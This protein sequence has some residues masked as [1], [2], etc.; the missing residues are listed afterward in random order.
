[1]FTRRVRASLPWLIAVVSF[2]FAAPATAAEL[3]IKPSA[4]RGSVATF[5]LRGITGHRVVAASLHS[6]RRVRR[7]SAKAIRRASTRRFA[8]LRAQ[9][10]SRRS[11]RLVVR[12]RMA[13]VRKPR[14][15]G[16]TTTTT[17]PTPTTTTTTTEPAPA[18]AP[19]PAPTATDTA[20]SLASVGGGVVP[21]AC[22]RPYS[23]DSPFN[24]PIPADARTVANSSA[25]VSRVTEWGTP[26]HLT[27]GH[28]DTADDWSHPTYYATAAD[29]AFTLRCTRA[30]G[31]CAIEGMTIRVPDAARA[32]GGGDAHM[33]IVDFASGWEYDLYDVESKPA[34]GGELRF[35]WGGRTRI[36][37]DGTGSAATASNFG[38]LAGIIRAPELAA[39]E[40]DHA[41]FMVVKCDS[42]QHVYPATKS[43]RSCAAMGLPTADAPPMGSR[44]QLM[45]TDAEIDALN[46]PA[47]KKTIF[48]AMARYGMYFGD[49]GS[50]AWA[51]QAESGSTYTSFGLE[52]ALVTYGRAAGVPTYNG[53]YVFN[54]RDGV[55]WK[56]RLRVVAA[57]STQGTC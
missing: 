47:Y 49:T 22:W 33:T 32:A 44:F 30:W 12:V 54:I 7:V 26:N 5:D 57:C 43:G 38:N 42:G 39:G 18:P 52:D 6:G 29:P 1:M 56:S 24:K 35:G 8:R 9:R 13:K 45:M 10:A 15:T 16:T 4:V 50:N 25:I 40:I 48:R 55:D 41:L 19:A 21:G 53:D 34:G 14:P 46:V 51:I 36:D 31:T 3:T 20:C 37:G 11:T 17:S 2:L 28:A 23:A 27:A